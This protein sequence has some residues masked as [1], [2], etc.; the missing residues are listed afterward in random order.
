MKGELATNGPFSAYSNLK[1]PF[2]FLSSTHYIH[3]FNTSNIVKCP[4]NKSC[5]MDYDPINSPIYH[6]LVIHKRK[7]NVLS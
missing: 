6:K 4:R 5:E 3:H 2:F 7:T 1:D